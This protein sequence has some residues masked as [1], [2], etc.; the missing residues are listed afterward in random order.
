MSKGK[1]FPSAQKEILE[2]MDEQNRPLAAFPRAE[3]HRLGLLHR[4]VLVL[5]YNT[6]NQLYLQQRSSQKQPYP[7]C[8]DLSATGHV[9]LGES[10][11]DAAQRELTEELGIYIKG[12]R[13]LRELSASP[14]TGYEFVYLYSAGRCAQ[15][16]NPD[17]AEIQTGAFLHKNELDILAGSF[18]HLLTPG[19]LYFWRLGILFG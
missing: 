7:G 4:S 2:V 5:V 18:A 13:L 3:V 16:P 6:N 10:T 9:Q 8:W 11:L 19:L 15:A 1:T 14:E 12:L 17:P